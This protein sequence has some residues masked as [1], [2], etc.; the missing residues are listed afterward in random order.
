MRILALDLKNIKTAVAHRSAIL[1]RSL[2]HEAEIVNSE[3]ENI[4]GDDV[5]IVRKC[6]PNRK[7]ITSA[8]KD[9]FVERYNAGASMGEIARLY[10]CH[11]T[12]VSRALRQRG[13]ESGEQL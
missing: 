12:T 2:T 3:K 13:V 4:W 5:K 6:T 10:K 1:N 9:E 8:E 7:P 11:H